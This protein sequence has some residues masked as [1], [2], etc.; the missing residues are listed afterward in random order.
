MTFQIDALR[1]KFPALGV[2]QLSSQWQSI[3]GV[4]GGV[5]LENDKWRVVTIT[6]LAQAYVD[7]FRTN[8]ADGFGIIPSIA[9][10]YIGVTDD[11]GLLRA[12]M[13]QI[14]RRWRSVL[15]QQSLL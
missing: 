6:D 3:G 7:T 4:S 12:L 9:A 11:S 2:T 10:D 8:G 1:G 15:H 5:G 13:P 14:E